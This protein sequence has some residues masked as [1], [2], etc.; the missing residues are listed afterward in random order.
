MY[1]CQHLIKKERKMES[2]VVHGSIMIK[3]IISPTKFQFLAVAYHLI[4]VIHTAV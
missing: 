3:C 4:L 2:K 1:I